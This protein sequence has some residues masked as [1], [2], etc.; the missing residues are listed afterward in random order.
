[1]RVT[2]PLT[3]TP[4]ILTSTSAAEPGAGETA[5]DVGATYAEGVRAISTT[6]HKV[7]ESLNDGNIGH[8][9]ATDD[10]TNWLEVGPTNRWKM[11]DLYRSTGTTGASPLTVKLT[12]GRRVDTIGLLGVIAD[13]VTITVRVGAVVV[14]SATEDL[15]TRQVASWSGYFFTPF[16]YRSTVYQFALPPMTGAEVEVTFT[17]SAGE[18]SCGSLVL[19]TSAYLGTTLQGAVSDS[20]NFSEVGRDQFGIAT[21]VPRRSI[22]KIN[23]TTIIEKGAVNVVRSVREQLNAVPALWSWLDD[24]D[25]G[26]F[27]A[28]LILGFYT[29]FTI[30]LDQP[31]IDYA[32]VALELEEV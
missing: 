30:T 24:Q 6:T 8:D 10:G 2:P 18:V 32:T 20:L 28:G 21:L 11:F 14:Y 4:A 29:R 15:R 9:P 26:Y 22:P 25:D 7:Y 31:A 23:P 3:I 13:H 12:P 1:M 17:K 16:A 27:E 5:W 19:G